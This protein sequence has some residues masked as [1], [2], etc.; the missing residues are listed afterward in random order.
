MILRMVELSLAYINQALGFTAVQSESP[1]NAFPAMQKFDVIWC[2]VMSA[3]VGFALCLMSVLWINFL[4]LYHP[5]NNGGNKRESIH[6][7]R[8]IYSNVTCVNCQLFERSGSL[9]V[10]LYAPMVPARV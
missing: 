4:S 6:V 10:A 5:N 8:L 1:A 9:C 7:Q 2:A 3:L